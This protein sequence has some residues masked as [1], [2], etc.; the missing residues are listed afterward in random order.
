[1]PTPTTAFPDVKTSFAL[2]LACLFCAG[3]LMA[4]PIASAAVSYEKESLA[5]YEKQLASG[6][7]SAATI[8][9]YI[10]TLRITLKD[11]RHVLVKYPKH[12][13]PATA[14]HL[15][16]KGVPVSVL[17]PTAAREEAKLK[18]HKHKLRYIVGGILIVVI[19]VVAA[20]V[21]LVV[22]RRRQ[23]AEE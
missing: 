3:S 8:N 10:R 17:A 9:K 13:E 22:R 12:Q 1:M 4:A 23:A 11:G 5:E 21:L 2:A 6:Q 14:A 16:A 19:V 15:Q 18:H 20:V 7:V